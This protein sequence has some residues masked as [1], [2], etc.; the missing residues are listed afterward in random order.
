[1]NVQGFFFITKIWAENIKYRVTTNTQT[2][3]KALFR[4]LKLTKS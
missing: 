4:Y 1:M 3:E 2:L